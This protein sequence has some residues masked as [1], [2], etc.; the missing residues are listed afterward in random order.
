MTRTESNPADSD[1]LL[2]LGRAI[3]ARRR[4]LGLTL[5]QMAALSGLSQPFLSQVERGQA[6]P[7][8]RSLGTIAQALGTTAPSLLALP[9]SA[10]VSL[11]H[12]GDVPSIDNSA[13]GTA[14]SIAVGARELL[15]ME[16]LGGPAEFE[17]YLE[18]EGEEIIY[19]VSGTIEVD[20]AGEERKTLSV[21]DSLYFDARVPHRWRVVSEPVWVIAVSTRAH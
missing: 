4:D 20:L 6:R 11:V 16:F 5:V 2:D 13:Q 3:R 8:M 21:R 14:R 12:A 15:P 19:V 18:H 9:R 7:S 1:A 17:E 10:G